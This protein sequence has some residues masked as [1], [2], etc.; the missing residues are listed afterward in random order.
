M[1]LWKVVGGLF[2]NRPPEHDRAAYPVHFT[3]AFY[4]LAGNPVKPGLGAM[5]LE[6]KIPTRLHRHEEVAPGELDLR[7]KEANVGSLDSFRTK[8]DVVW[9]RADKFKDDFVADSDALKL[10]ISEIDKW[11]EWYLPTSRGHLAKTAHSLTLRY[12][13]GSMGIT[14]GRDNAF[15]KITKA[16]LLVLKRYPYGDTQHVQARWIV[17]HLAERKH[18]E[19]LRGIPPDHRKSTF[20]YGKYKEH[21]YTLPAMYQYL[22]S[23]FRR[24]DIPG[25]LPR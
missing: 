23:E 11:L 9:T 3:T 25:L 22:I 6:L 17:E 4:K 1:N 14:R 21:D 15:G 16:L 10:G 2:F 13:R 20:E 12:P 8:L 7:L 18:K 19:P 5:L 24:R